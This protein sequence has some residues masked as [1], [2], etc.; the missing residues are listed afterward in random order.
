MSSEQQANLTEWVEDKGVKNNYK[1]VV[2]GD[3]MTL[4]KNI[5][6]SLRIFGLTKQPIP[7]YFYAKDEETVNQ[8]IA[9][10]KPWHSRIT[11]CKINYVIAREEAI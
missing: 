9:K 11:V 2:I 4:R 5:I 10:M 6:L 7:M 1:F 3:G 8:I